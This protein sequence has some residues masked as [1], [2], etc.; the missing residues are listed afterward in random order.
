VAGAGV[1][2]DGSESF[3]ERAAAEGSLGRMRGVEIVPM[4]ARALRG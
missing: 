3:G 1:G 2:A 4:L